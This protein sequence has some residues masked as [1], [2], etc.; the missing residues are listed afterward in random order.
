MDTEIFLAE[1]FESPMNSLRVRLYV[2]GGWA[3]A[4]VVQ[5][6]GAQS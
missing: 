6:P 3:L 5:G 1:T 4:L 2:C